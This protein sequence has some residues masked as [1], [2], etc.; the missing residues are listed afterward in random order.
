[1]VLNIEAKALII[2][3]IEDGKPFKLE[4]PKYLN[5]IYITMD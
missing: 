5:K 3:N 4:I 1:M 2:M